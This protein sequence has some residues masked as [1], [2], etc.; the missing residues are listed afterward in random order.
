MLVAVGGD[1]APALAYIAEG[2]E[3]PQQAPSVLPGANE[4]LPPAVPQAATP[5]EQ[6]LLPPAAPAAP[7]PAA[8]APTPQNLPLPPPAPVQHTIQ[9]PALVHTPPPPQARAPDP[10]LALESRSVGVEG[11]MTSSEL[12]LAHMHWVALQQQVSA[13]YVQQVL[14]VSLWERQQLAAMAIASSDPNRH[15]HELDDAS[16]SPASRHR[17]RYSDSLFL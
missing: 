13:A 6:A 11:E 4:P 8:Q 14:A 5:A 3:P 7:A 9:A 16:S 12:A 10:P 2:P 15:Q 1:A 17:R